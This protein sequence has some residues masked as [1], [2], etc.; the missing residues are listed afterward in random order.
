MHISGPITSMVRSKRSSSFKTGRGQRRR[1][2]RDDLAGQRSPPILRASTQDLTSYDFYLRAL[3]NFPWMGKEQLLEALDLLERAI[4]RD[5]FYGPAHAW[6][7]ICHF[8]LCYDG[9]AG[10]PEDSRRKALGLAEEALALADGDPGVLANAAHVLGIWGE[11]INTAMALVDR[12]V[13]LNPS[14][15][16]GWY[17]SGMLRVRAGQCDA[18]IE[19]LEKSFAAQP[20]RVSRSSTVLLGLAHSS[21][22]GVSI[23]PRSCLP[24]RRTN[25]PA[26]PSLSRSRVVLRAYGTAGRS[27]RRRR[28]TAGAD[29]Q[30]DTELS[31]YPNPD[32]R[33]L[34][35][36]GLRLAAGE[37]I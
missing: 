7:A 33:E 22:V 15:A 18:A 5:P 8:R 37:E 29:A 20:S 10:D 9:W 34:F 26:C 6:A 4:A 11:D 27:P 23:R 36:S 19:Q 21:L 30:C 24:C 2:H 28:A 12:C 17:V 14:Y 3:A 35:L 31:A 13:S 1:R 16:R 32:Q 25:L